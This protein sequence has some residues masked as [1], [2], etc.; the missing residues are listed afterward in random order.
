MR[1]PQRPSRSS[2]VWKTT[3]FAAAIIRPK[4]CSATTGAVLPG[5]FETVIPS[6]FAVTRSI[7]SVPMPKTVMNFSVGSWRSTS[8]GHLTAP[9]ELSR[10]VAPWA[11]SICCSTLVGRSV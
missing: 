8:P 9:R 7:E 2:P 3:R 1:V 10:I 11:R 4:A 6:S 5:M